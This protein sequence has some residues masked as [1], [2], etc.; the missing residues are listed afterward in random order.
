MP[1][2]LAALRGELVKLRRVRGTFLALLLFAP[3]SLAIGAL[4]GASAR[5]ALDTHSPLL[6]ADFTPEQTGLD[7]IMYGQLALIVFAVLAVAGEY[8]SGMLRTSLLAVPGRGRLYLAKT[9]ATALAALAVGA[10]VTVAGYLVTQYALGP[11]GAGL[12]ADGV[13]V[14]LVGAA[15]YLVLMS[16]FAAGLAAAARNAV[17]PLVVLL[18]MVL[19]GSHLLS[20]LGATR[21]LA[22][23]LPDRAGAE[24]L[25][26]GSHDQARGLL[27]LLAWTA[28]ALAL[29]LL[30][31]RR[32]DG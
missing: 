3:V 23:Y 18:P 29:G 30:R 10:P 27:V 11:H 13:P 8:G 32:W 6:R 20:L 14:A 19:A 4:D 16:L 24:L 12:G 21:Q 31:L 15:G 9:A 5:S 2:A 25:T 17:V 7:G 22:R 26:V 1:E 28:A